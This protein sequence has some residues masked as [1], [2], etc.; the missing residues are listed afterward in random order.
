[1]YFFTYKIFFFCYKIVCFSFH[2]DADS[3]SIYYNYHEPKVRKNNIPECTAFMDYVEYI[4]NTFEDG[5]HSYHG[6]DELEK[7]NA[8]L[9]KKSCDSKQ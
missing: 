5:K 8:K 4:E 6:N 2:L 1:M 7:N 3:G 9:F